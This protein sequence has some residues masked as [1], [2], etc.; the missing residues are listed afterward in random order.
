MRFPCLSAILTIAAIG[1]G[2]TARFSVDGSTST[3][4][5]TVTVIQP[6]P[7]APGYSWLRIYFYSSP[8]TA[9]DL[10]SARKGRVDEIKAK[11]GAVLQLT[12]DKDSN[13]WQVDLAL[14]GHTCTIAASD[15]EAKSAIQEFHFDGRHVR[16][17]G[18]GSHTCDM[19]FTQIPNQTFE[20]NIDVDSAVAASAG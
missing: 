10:A 17:R 16:L 7:G 2:S 3:A 6:R 13:V 18:M 14:P 1:Y 20:W 19:R 11:W 15:R 9:D 5:T 4:S 12:L 8:L